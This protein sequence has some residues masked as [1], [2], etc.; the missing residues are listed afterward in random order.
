MPDD[1]DGTREERNEYLRREL[2]AELDACL[3]EDEED[4]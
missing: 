3:D 2:Q 4:L 1:F